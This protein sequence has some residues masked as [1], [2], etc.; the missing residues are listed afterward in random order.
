MICT[1]WNDSAERREARPNSLLFE[2]LTF[3]AQQLLLFI[4]W[5][6]ARFVSDAAEKK[7]THPRLLSVP[8]CSH[9]NDTLLA[10]HYLPLANQ[11]FSKKSCKLEV[12]SAHAFVHTDSNFF[13]SIKVPSGNLM[14]PK[15][16]EFTQQDLF[17]FGLFKTSLSIS[18]LAIP[19][20]I[21]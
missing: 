18:M 21:I 2:S 17:L 19:N 20:L 10:R 5:P 3:L 15:M 1:Y 4:I 16:R 11:F 9:D 13:A 8:Q 12:M 14:T 7:L 6:C